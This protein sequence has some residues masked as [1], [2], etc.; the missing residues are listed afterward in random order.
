ML[1]FNFVVNSNKIIV[2]QESVQ[3]LKIMENDTSIAQ[4]NGDA[5]VDKVKQQPATTAPY[6]YT[7]VMK[8]MNAMIISRLCRGLLTLINL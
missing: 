4:K 6:R 8:N 2:G 1:N 5:A 3:C 7:K